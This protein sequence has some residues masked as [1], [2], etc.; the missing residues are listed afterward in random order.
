MAA[1]TI[2]ERFQEVETMT[3]VAFCTKKL[4]S[5]K[6]EPQRPCGRVVYL[7]IYPGDTVPSEFACFEHQPKVRAKRKA[8]G[9]K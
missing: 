6:H 8:K 2:V 5:T 7:A 4:R 3:L 9:Q 1:G